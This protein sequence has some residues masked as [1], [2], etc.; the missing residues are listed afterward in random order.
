MLR[1]HQPPVQYLPLTPMPERK[2]P[3]PFPVL[4]SRVFP[5]AVPLHRLVTFLNRA[6]KRRGYA[7]GLEQTPEGMRLTVYDLGGS[8]EDGP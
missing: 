5:E 2:L 7:F 1:L 3:G 6:L 4:D 8:K